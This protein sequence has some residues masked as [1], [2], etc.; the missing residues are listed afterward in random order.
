LCKLERPFYTKKM[1]D[2]IKRVNVTQYN[3]SPDTINIIEKKAP[4]DD[5]ARLYG[6]LLEK[7]KKNI[8]GEVRVEDNSMNGS[9]LF[10]CSTLENF[11][12]IQYATK[13]TLNNIEHVVRGEFSHRDVLWSTD[14]NRKGVE[15]LFKSISEQIAIQ[16]LRDNEKT[17]TTTW[18]PWMI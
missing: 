13:F 7:A 6:E 18:A 8:I 16:I 5:S 3:S 11:G 2:T 12:Q 15:L 1:F 17:L 10:F 9:V 4:T 14:K